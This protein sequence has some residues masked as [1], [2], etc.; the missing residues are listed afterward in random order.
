MK[1]SEKYRPSN[2]NEIIMNAARLLCY[3]HQDAF[4]CQIYGDEYTVDV[5]SY[6]PADEL[7]EYVQKLRPRIKQGMYP[8]TLVSEGVLRIHEFTDRN[9]NKCWQFCSEH[10]YVDIKCYCDWDYWDV[11][12]HIAISEAVNKLS[13]GIHGE[14]FRMIANCIPD[15]ISACNEQLDKAANRLLQL[16]NT[17]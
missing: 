13:D 3:E 1:K 17:R 2:W 9:N 14:E 7:S 12:S 4:V 11:Q 16:E 6:L 10:F 15:V 5:F 8:N